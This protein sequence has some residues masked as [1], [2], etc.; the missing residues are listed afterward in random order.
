MRV[1]EVALYLL[2]DKEQRDKPCRL[3]RIHRQDQE[4][5]YR[6]A[7]E[8]PENGNQSGKRNQHAHKQG[9]REPQYRHGYKEHRAKNHSLQALPRQE[10]RKRTGSQPADA[11]DRFRAFFFQIGEKQLAHLPAQRF[12]LQKD[13]AGENKG[14]K[15]R[16]NRTDNA[17]CRTDGR[18]KHCIYAD[19][20]EINN[21]RKDFV[22]VQLEFLEPA[23]N[24][25]VFG[26]MRFQPLK[27]FR[28][29]QA[30]GGNRTCQLRQ[31]NHD[32]QPQYAG[33][34][35]N[36][37]QQADRHGGTFHLTALCGAAKQALLDTAHGNI[38]NKSNRPAKQER[39]KDVQNETGGTYHNIE[40]PQPHKYQQS[41]N[42]K[43]LYFT[44]CIPVEHKTSALPF[45][46]VILPNGLSNMIT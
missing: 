30:Q 34:S 33:Y 41:K 11:Q 38:Q 4:R 23:E 35:Q 3:Y 43:L 37:N 29:F 36:R 24:F 44:D 31:D 8:C 14:D 45:I 25:R 18:T 7:N 16:C 9:I 15:K 27:H 19:I 42:D 20:E 40:P 13:I 17:F 46:N 12:L 5:A 10:I 26:E 1:N 32:H 21:L 2:K 22:P 39:R 6:T 28:N